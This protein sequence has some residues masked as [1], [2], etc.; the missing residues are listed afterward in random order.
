M[1]LSFDQIVSALLLRVE[2]VVGV[3]HLLSNLRLHGSDF[4]NI[5]MHDLCGRGRGGCGMIA[6]VVAATAS[7][8]D[9]DVDIAGGAA[10][11]GAELGR[12]GTER[13]ARQLAAIGGLV[14]DSIDFRVVGCETRR[15]HEFGHLLLGF[16][17]VKGRLERYNAG[18]NNASAEKHGC[19]RPF[20]AA[21]LGECAAWE[22]RRA[23]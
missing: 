17:R 5:V 22:E 4:L 6:T 23:L 14:R 12:A 9:I 19:C 1:H 15:T 7:A 2:L 3:S 13:D 21:L 16:D 20:H 11:E 10:V 18:H 8:D